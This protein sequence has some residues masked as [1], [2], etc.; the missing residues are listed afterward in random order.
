MILL[1]KSLTFILWNVAIG[2][3][4]VYLLTWFLF[5]TKPRKIFGRRVPFTPGYLVRKRNWIFSK[6]RDLLHDYLGQAEDAIN[7]HG[8]LA[9]WEKLIYETVWE[10]TNFIDEW[11]L[12]PAKIKAK[13]H[14]KLSDFAKS[15]VSSI[16]R[17]TVPHLI[18]E[19]RLEHRIDDYDFQFSI[20]FFY[21]YYSKYFK[22]PVMLTFLVINFLIGI[23]NMI[24]FLIVAP[25]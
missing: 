8:Y 21:G 22:K 11:P 4:L 3:S 23:S 25:L 12:I 1:L 5:N 20:D 24:L 7:K 16:L 15:I 18:E 14:D 19:W 17:K 10:K 9:R 2:A 13:L 6:A